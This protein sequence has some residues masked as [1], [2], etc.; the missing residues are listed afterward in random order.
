MSPSQQPLP[1]PYHFA[2]LF[3]NFCASKNITH[4]LTFPYNPQSNGLAENAVKQTKHLLIKSLEN[5][6]NFQEAL[7]FYRNLPNQSGYSPAELLFGRRQK[8]PIPTLSE[9][10]D[11]INIKVA[12]ANQDLLRERAKNN[13]NKHARSQTPLST[14]DKVPVQDT[15]THRW[16]YTGYITSVLPNNISFKVQLPTGQVIIRGRIFLKPLPV[17][18]ISATPSSSAPSTLQQ[19]LIPLHRQRQGS[20]SISVVSFAL[21]VIELL[22]AKLLSS[23]LSR[24]WARLTNVPYCITGGANSRFA[25]KK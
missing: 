12:T 14:G 1:P 10:H 7:S 21:K 2:P 13:Y 17:P 24:L 5:N 18:N 22:C 4:E 11:P 23:S 8:L 6:E 9:H 15:D 20:K 3:D 19:Q 25:K 16:C